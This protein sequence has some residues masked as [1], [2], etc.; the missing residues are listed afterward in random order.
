MVWA[1]AV[2]VSD[3]EAQAGKDLAVVG[4]AVT[5]AA[6]VAAAVGEAAGAAMGVTVEAVMVL[7]M[8]VGQLIKPMPTMETTAAAAAAM[9]RAPRRMTPSAQAPII[10]DRVKAQVVGKVYQTA[11]E[12]A[13]AKLG[14]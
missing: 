9:L 14:C 6:A 7:A 10:E 11:M 12:A 8:L 1:K 5:V 2:G 4:A 3:R 13:S